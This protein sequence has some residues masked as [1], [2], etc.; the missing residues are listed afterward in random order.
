MMLLASCSTEPSEPTS[1]V[2]PSSTPSS[3]TTTTTPSSSLT[4]PL[5]FDFANEY[6]SLKTDMPYV[7]NADVLDGTMNGLAFKLSAAFVSSYSNVG[8]LMLGS[9]KYTTAAFIASAESLGKITKIE[10]TTGAS[11]SNKATYNVTFSETP[12]TEAVSD[13]AET[14]AQN[15]SKEFTPSDD[16]NYGYFAITSANTGANGQLATLT[17]TFENN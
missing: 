1:S 4:S 15:T 17:I 2:A 14:I 3:T 11:A 8:Y 9:K 10:F 5:T 16:K 13:G 7:E 6:D 12:I